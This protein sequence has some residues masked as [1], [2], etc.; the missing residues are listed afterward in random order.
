MSVTVSRRSFFVL[1]TSAAAF[2]A[3]TVLSPDATACCPAPP[4][5]KPVVN[6]DQTVLIVWDSATKTQHFIRQASF[7][8]ASDDFGFLI[9]TPT[10]PAL[11]ES[12]DAAFP[13]LAKIT[14]PKV[15]PM[16]P[17]PKS[18]CIGGCSDKSAPGS[19]A[20]IAPV[21]VLSEKAV[22]GFN[23]TVLEASSADALVGWLKERGYAF[24]PEVAAWAK[25]YVDGGWKITA[26]RVA[27]KPGDSGPIDAKALRLTFKTDRPLFPY[28]EP[29]PPQ[30][31]QIGDLKARLLRIYFL[32]DGRYQ[33]TLT[34]EVPWT[35]KVAY[36]GKVDD[37]T[38]KPITEALGIPALAATTEW[39]LTEFEDAWPY[40]IAPADLYFAKTDTQDAVEREP[41]YGAVSDGKSEIGYALAAA[42]LLPFVRRLARNSAG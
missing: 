11:D 9:P 26:L 19:A 20:G 27:K 32:S 36:S 12:G 14:A 34:P 4:E 29:A 40:K 2:T 28:R 42:A 35:G 22:A 5:G 8:G 18:S 41:V 17:Q 24:S 33:G 21:R 6:A 3:A 13:L 39:W 30:G 25:P 15:L 38:L 7:K 23:A 16:P 37:E 10:A 31:G 1:G